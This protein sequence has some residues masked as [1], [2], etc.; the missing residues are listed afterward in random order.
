MVYFFFFFVVKL[1]VIDVVF[2]F[3]KKKN[4][5]FFNLKKLVQL[6]ILYNINN[7]FKGDVLSK[8]VYYFVKLSFE[9]NDFK[10]IQYYEVNI[11]YKCDVVYVK[12]KLENLFFVFLCVY[13]SFYDYFMLMKYIFLVVILCKFGEL[14]CGNDS[15]IFFFNVFDIGYIGIYYIG[16]YYYENNSYIDMFFYKR[17]RR[18]VDFKIGFWS[19][20]KD[21]GR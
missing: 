15:Y 6:Y 7:G 19:Y 11:F 13:V 5:F 10:F 9:I 2:Q 20:C 12:L 3:D 8:I 18:S 16:I 4:L 21:G 1:W 17:V 14:K